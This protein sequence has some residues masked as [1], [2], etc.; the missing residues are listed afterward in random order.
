MGP[1]GCKY[2]EGYAS[3]EGVVNGHNDSLFRLLRMAISDKLSIHFLQGSY[4]DYLTRRIRRLII[5]K[6][7]KAVQEK[8]ITMPLIIPMDLQTGITTELQSRYDNIPADAL[9]NL[10]IPVHDPSTHDPRT[11]T[12]PPLF[13]TVTENGNLRYWLITNESMWAGPHRALDEVA[14]IL[15][16]LFSWFLQHENKSDPSTMQYNPGTD[17][18]QCIWHLA[19]SF[20]RRLVLPNASEKI[21][22]GQ[23]LPDRETLLFRAWALTPLPRVERSYDEDNLYMIRFQRAL[24]RELVKEGGIPDELFWNEGD[25]GAWGDEEGVPV[26]RD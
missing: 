17:N 3:F 25:E 16:S 14:E 23:I 6:D 26:W 8:Q 21:E 20:R 13:D 19:E 5:G 1:Q 22:R 2:S 9:S 7:L 24:D 11:A 4:V 15:N 12:L 18:P 10:L